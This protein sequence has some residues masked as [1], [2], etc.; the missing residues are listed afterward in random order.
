[1]AKLREMPW[2]KSMLVKAGR[3]VSSRTVHNLNA[4]LNYLDAGRWM[5][6]RGLRVERW[7]KDRDA[8][9]ELVADRIRD[10]RVLLIELG[11]FKGRYI[12]YWAKQ[13]GHPQAAI[14]GFDSF[15]GLPEDWNFHFKREFFSLGGKAPKFG[16]PRIELFAGWFH[17]TLPTYRPAPHDLLFV[18]FDADLY[19]STKVALDNL[20]AY[21]VP[22]TLLYFDEFCDRLHEKRAFDEYLSETGHGYRILAADPTLSNVL[23]ERIS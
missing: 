4:A 10:K 21:F 15:V 11:V 19:S 13:L 17:E 6:D 9:N 5:R 23:F 14:H 20:K 1:M 22:G 18:N 3:L 2:Y 12:E 16:D 7:V 8:I